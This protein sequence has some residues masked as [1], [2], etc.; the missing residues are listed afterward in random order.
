M[1][2]RMIQ[3]GLGGRGAHW[4][5]LLS[6]RTDVEPVAYVDASSKVIE[7]VKARPGFAE[8]R[9]FASMEEALKSVTADFVL[10]ATPSF[11][12]AQQTLQALDAG[13]AVLVEKPYGM[14][15]AEASAVAERARAVGRPVVV[16]ENFRF[17]PAER[18]LRAFL[19][20]GAAGRIGN[21]TVVDRRDQPSRSQGSWVQSMPHPFLT[22]IGV[23]HFDS[24]RFLLGSEPVSVLARSYNPHDSDY[25][26][27]G[28]A[29]ALF[30][31]ASGA[32]IQYSG[33]FC[34]PR[35]EYMMWI[36]AERGEVRTD[37]VQVWWR[38]RGASKFGVLPLQ[39]LPA[40]ETARYPLAGMQTIFEQFC[41]T[42]DGKGV[43]ETRGEDNL[44]TL[45]MLDAA[46]LSVTEKRTVLMSEIIP[47]PG[48]S[49]GVSS[50][51][52]GRA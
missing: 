23:H 25:K 2:R 38:P 27:D 21:V 19:D 45:A 50:A 14:N 49:D 7:Q 11:L 30:E 39:P 41:A 16:A 10:I 52:E 22:E 28:A 51:A 1:K 8:R 31:F 48:R 46:I 4:L 26:H 29:Q 20:T 13:L 24:F 12:H 18:T 35:Y 37:R 17:F 36:E 32:T 44:R 9:F 3:I 34:A 47:G 43:A 42:L 40:G 15:V 5:D 6:A 33:T